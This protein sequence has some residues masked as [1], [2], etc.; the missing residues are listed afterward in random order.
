MGVS[1][2]PPRV[3][4]R[5]GRP[6]TKRF[7]FVARRSTGGRA[8]LVIRRVRRSTASRLSGPLCRG[9]RPRAGCWTGC[10]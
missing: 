3:D 6:H 2:R 10:G 7:G 1:R 5:W 9:R 8:V 4:S